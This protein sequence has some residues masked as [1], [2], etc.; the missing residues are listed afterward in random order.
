MSI[1]VYNNQRANKQDCLG[2]PKSDKTIS[3]LQASKTNVIIR[4]LYN[5]LL[6]RTRRVKTSDG[7]TSYGHTSYG[8]ISCAS[9]T[10][11]INN[12]PYLL[13]LCKLCYM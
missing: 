2:S 5:Q 8:E 3:F 9:L 11:F 10:S 1:K 13:M 4:K 12:I 7:E 6:Q